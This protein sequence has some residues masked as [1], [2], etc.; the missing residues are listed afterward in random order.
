MLTNLKE[1][2]RRDTESRNNQ[3]NK[4]KIMMTVQDKMALISDNNS[5]YS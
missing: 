1:K 4:S 5:F 2:V 3:H